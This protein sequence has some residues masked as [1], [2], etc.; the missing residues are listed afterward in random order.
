[1]PDTAN[2][3][4]RRHP[5]PAAVPRRWA[6]INDTAAYLGI[7]IRTVREM[8]AD[9]RLTAYRGLGSRVIRIDLNEVDA[10]MGKAG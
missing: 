10:A 4:A 6:S 3:R 5:A 2:R 7:G 1:M 9:G 8:L